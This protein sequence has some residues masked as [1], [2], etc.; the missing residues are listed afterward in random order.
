MADLKIS[1]EVATAAMADLLKD[2]EK[3]ILAHM[4]RRFV[5][6]ETKAAGSHEA[7]A[8]YNIHRRVTKLESD[9]RRLEKEIRE[10][11]GGR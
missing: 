10:L 1:L 7:S 4:E 6:A 2:Q 8:I 3:K 11:R 9:N 5:L